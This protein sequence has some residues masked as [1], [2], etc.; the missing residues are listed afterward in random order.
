MPAVSILFHPRFRES[1]LSSIPLS[2]RLR[3]VTIALALAAVATT[4]WSICAFVEHIRP[5][6]VV[7][8]AFAPD[9]TELRVVQTCNWS[10]E[11][12][13][14]A[15]YYRRS[16]GAWGWF[17][18]DH[19]DLYWHRG[20]AEVDPQSKRI[21]VFRGRRV[22]VTFDWESERFRLLRE[23]CQPREYVGA[24]EWTSPPL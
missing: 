22:V 2:M 17:Y 10:A 14:T 1:A 3:R 11:P 4:V 15:V 7:A 19:Q 21:S 9:G 23:G 24:Q 20:R 18:Y 16:G 5:P 13:T 8:R 12:F 6:R